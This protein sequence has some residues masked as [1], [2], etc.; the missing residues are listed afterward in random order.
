MF[1]VLPCF[2]PVFWRV[3]AHWFNL[4]MILQFCKLRWFCPENTPPFFSLIALGVY[5]PHL[6]LLPAKRALR[7]PP[8]AA[9]CPHRHGNLATCH[10]PAEA[11][12][13]IQR[14][15]PGSGVRGEHNRLSYPE[16]A[17]PPY[18]RQARAFTVVWAG[19]FLP[20]RPALG[21]CRRE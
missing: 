1:C 17:N 14:H 13:Q 18:H 6:L 4:C 2:S 15:R 10:V 11:Y 19:R 20:C 3:I 5:S 12:L 7:Y 9:F 21:H 8:V 16:P